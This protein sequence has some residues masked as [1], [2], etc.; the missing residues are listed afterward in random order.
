MEEFITLD[1]DALKAISADDMDV[2]LMKAAQSG[3]RTLMKEDGYGE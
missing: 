1:D 2:F 3:L